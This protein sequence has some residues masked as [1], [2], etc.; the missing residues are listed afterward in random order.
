MKFK[1]SNELLLSMDELTIPSKNEEEGISKLRNILKHAADNGLKNKWS[2][3]QILQRN[4]EFLGYI[5]E[6]SCIVYRK[7]KKQLK[8][9]QNQKMF[10]MF[11]HFWFNWT[12]PQFH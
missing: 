1:R 11:K 8:T 10:G 7:K 12:F 9:S 4:D 6:N 3:C 2:K 5:V